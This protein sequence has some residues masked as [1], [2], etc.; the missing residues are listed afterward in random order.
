MDIRQWLDRLGLG[1]YAE[2][3]MALGIQP[4]E[5]AQLTEADLRELGVASL[6]H[7]RRILQAAAGVAA[8]APEPPAR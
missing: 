6:V 5:A 3:F 4:H 1:Q 2:A 7:R 8:T